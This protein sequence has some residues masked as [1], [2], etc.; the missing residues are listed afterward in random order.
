M[1]VCAWIV[2]VLPFVDD[3]HHVIMQ[4]ILIAPGAF[5]NSLGADQAAQCIEDG[6]RRSGIDASYVHC[7]IAD[8]GNGTLDAFCAA[9]EK[10]ASQRHTLSV[11]DPLGRTVQA[12]F[13][14]LPNKVAVIEMAQASG[15]E[16]LQEHE[17]DPMG[18]STY[19]TG[20]LILAAL[21]AGAQTIIIGLGGSATVDGG[22]GCMQA[23]GAVFYED[24]GEDA[25][26]LIPTGVGGG[27]L[28]Q[29]RHIA[30]DNFDQ[31][32][33]Q[34]KIIIA[35]DVDNPIIGADGSA[36]TFAPQKGANEKHVALLAAGLNNFFMLIHQHCGLDVREHAGAG[37]AGSIA[38]SLMALCGGTLE[39]GFELWQQYSGFTAKVSQADV[40]ITGEGR[41]DAQT[42][43]GKG[44]MG[45][46]LIAR[47]AGISTV[48][49]VGGLAV[50]DQLLHQAGIDVVFPLCDQPMSLERAI[51]QAPDLLRASACRLG[52]AL[53]L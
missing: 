18:A 30:L 27:T 25:D 7:P 1:S 29:V 28:S 53:Q 49:M 15:L 36:E 32:I 40:L 20:Q 42:I 26:V 37:A 23:L 46:A 21:D 5:K 47:Q 35:C 16:L 3:R 6:L 34:T 10:G 22:I 14:M 9:A 39:G 12:E 43:H 52:Y 50:D 17:L 2:I 8:G 4:K 19:G 31:R 24:E 45:A 11:Q 13:A 38:G 41:M 51:A 33:A 48:A 44:P